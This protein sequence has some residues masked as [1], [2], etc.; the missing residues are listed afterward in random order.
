MDA[1]LALLGESKTPTIYRPKG[2]PECGYTGY[3]GRTGIYEL[4]HVDHTMRGLIHDSEAEDKLRD[5]ATGLGMHNLRQDGMRWA[6][7]GETS[8]EEVLRVAR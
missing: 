1:E 2:C 6:A 7:K 5:H 3:Q 4:L 8:L